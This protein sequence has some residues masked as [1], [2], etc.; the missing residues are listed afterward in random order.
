MV[1]DENEADGV[2]NVFSFPASPEASERMS[3]RKRAS[4]EEDVRRARIFR[5]AIER[6]DRPELMSWPDRF[7]LAKNLRDFVYRLQDEG[8]LRVRDLAADVRGPNTPREVRASN[9]YIAP[10]GVETGEECRAKHPNRRFARKALAFKK[11]ALAAARRAGAD[12]REAILELVKGSSFWPDATAV[13]EDRRQAAIQ[14]GS[15]LE[16]LRRP[17]DAIYPLERYFDEVEEH[18][19]LPDSFFPEDEQDGHLKFDCLSNPEELDYLRIPRILLAQTTLDERKIVM[20]TAKDGDAEADFE[21]A[22]MAGHS[23][24]ETIKR[25]RYFSLGMARLGPQV[26][27]VGI[28]THKTDMSLLGSLWGWVPYSSFAGWNRASFSTKDGPV[29]FA[30]RLGEEDNAAAPEE[31]SSDVYIKVLDADFLMVPEPG[32]WWV[33]W[34][35]AGAEPF[36]SRLGGFSNLAAII[37][38]VLIF[39]RDDETLKMKLEA[40]YR[41]KVEALTTWRQQ[42]FD[43]IEQALEKVRA[44]L[45]SAEPARDVD[46]DA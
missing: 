31:S 32:S 16:L 17:L 15:V 9:E 10:M 23:T 20:V 24:T 30:W 43:E 42:T 19:L 3:A 36:F 14:V 39:D 27:P 40:D 6:L 4:I 37:E 13:T 35:S 7:T 12:E 28:F 29:Q 26:R 18:N 38:H 21:A 1:K 34:Q 46:P 22:V 2:N 25:R 33:E 5:N 44:N 45:L 11:M 8:R 41:K